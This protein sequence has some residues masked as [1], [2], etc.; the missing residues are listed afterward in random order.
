MNA[1]W[2]TQGYNLRCPQVVRTEAR[3]TGDTI[4]ATRHVTIN[5]NQDLMSSSDVIHLLL[6][7]MTTYTVDVRIGSRALLTSPAEIRAGFQH[8][9][10]YHGR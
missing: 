8:L 7:T 3:S 9:S 4:V 1:Q 5:L 10:E 2:C 6:R